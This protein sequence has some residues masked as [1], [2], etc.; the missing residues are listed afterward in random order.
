[1]DL[2]FAVKLMTE[3]ALYFSFA[4]FFPALLFNA[5]LTV[6]APALLFAGG[7][8]TYLWQQKIR[9]RTS[10]GVLT[11]P[12]TVPFF[13][14]LPLIL[15]AGSLFFAPSLLQLI[16][17]LPPWAYL[18]QTAWNQNYEITYSGQHDRFFLG[19]KVLPL[20]LVPVFFSLRFANFQLFEARCLPFILLYLLGGIFTLRLVRHH[21]ETLAD[22]RFKLIHFLT[23]LLFC[24]FCLSLSSPLLW[25]YVVGGLGFFYEKLLQPLI[26][27]LAGIIA[28]PFWGLAILLRKLIGIRSNPGSPSPEIGLGP[29]PDLPWQAV[30]PAGRPAW[31]NI[32]LLAAAV[33]FLLTAYLVLKRMAGRKLRSDAPSGI[34]E[35]RR[36][37]DGGRD[38]R[39]LFPPSADGPAVRFYYRKFLRLCQKQGLIFQAHQTSR[40]IQAAVENRLPQKAPELERLRRLYLQA[41]YDEE[42]FHGQA[43]ESK[44][45]YQSI[46]KGFSD[47][48]GASKD[49]TD[50][51]A[52]PV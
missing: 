27:V 50:N 47:K 28:L 18:I 16:L 2:V 40:D 48:A 7:F 46:K 21:K 3:L 13:T 35:T 20:T 4:N 5:P 49:K 52:R 36:A 24:L 12:G 51:G 17:L 9:R 45:L 1:M 44:E 15:P 25:S 8:L 23:L 42:H 30:E 39:D 34:V 32:L 33:I 6:A 10:V 31:L 41:R 38:P 11:S 29:D 37:L 22:P 19:L 14:F 43:K 26:L